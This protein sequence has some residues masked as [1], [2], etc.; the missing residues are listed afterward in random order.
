MDTF[1]R[2]RKI[3]KLLQMD[4]DTAL[5]YCKYHELYNYNLIAEHFGE[6]HRSVIAKFGKM[7]K[8]IAINLGRQELIDSEWLY[9]GYELSQDEQYVEIV[10]SNKPHRITSHGVILRQEN[11][12]YFPGR[13]GNHYLS[14]WVEV[15][16]V[17]T[18]GNHRGQFVVKSKGKSN[19]YNP[20]ILVAQYWLPDY[21]QDKIIYF[22]NGEDINIHP[23]NMTQDVFEYANWVQRY[24][25]EK[26]AQQLINLIY[27]Q[28]NKHSKVD[29]W[30]FQEHLLHIG[31]DV[32]I[33]YKRCGLV[34]ATRRL[35][36]VM[37]PPHNNKYSKNMSMD[38][39]FS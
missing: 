17:Q 19:Y 31:F 9:E 6:G 23:E 25:L 30:D 22:K 28:E 24:G 10:L 16:Y 8:G 5:A 1:K 2:L 35:Y 29:L 13:G 26:S 33:D 38:W 11:K 27:K 37:F 18:Q 36:K 14:R 4:Y 3:D 7:F 34:V 39:L 20:R 15:K 32:E 12:S 21:N